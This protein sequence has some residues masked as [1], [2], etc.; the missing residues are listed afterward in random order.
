M[1]QREH[2]VDSL[3]MDRVSNYSLSQL[4]QEPEKL[5][6]LL[7]KLKME[8]EEMSVENYTAHIDNHRCLTASMKGLNFM[9]NE[10]NSFQGK[11]AMVREES[12]RFLENATSL[13]DKHKD[14]FSSQHFR[15]IRNFY[16]Y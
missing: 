5:K 4:R 11:I 3:Y 12:K 10:M 15:N 2:G 9:H 1:D 14:F 8:T 6:D 13:V 16:N 7:Q